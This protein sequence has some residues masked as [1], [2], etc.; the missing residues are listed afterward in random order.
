MGGYAAR[1]PGGKPRL[2]LEFLWSPVEILGTERVEGLRVVRNRIEPGSLRAVPT[3][4]ERVIECG[5]VVRSIGYRGIP[6]QGISFDERGGLIRN[7][8]GRVLEADG[9]V[10]TGSYAV[11]WIKRGIDEHETSAGEALGRPE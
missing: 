1:E 11:G 5:M 2:V 10:R 6:L 4:E 8:G 7:D 3:G 9:S